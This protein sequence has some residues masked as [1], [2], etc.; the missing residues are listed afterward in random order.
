MSQAGLSWALPAGGPHLWIRFLLA[1]RFLTRYNFTFS[2]FASSHAVIGVIG[3]VQCRRL[4][5]RLVEV[6]LEESF[7]L[8]IGQCHKD[9]SL[10]AMFSVWLSTHL[11]LLFA[12]VAHILALA[13]L[14]S[15]TVLC[16]SLGA[17]LLPTRSFCSTRRAHVLV[18][19]AFSGPSIESLYRMT[20]PSTF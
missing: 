11:C 16:P 20:Q 17:L 13:R 1:G 8:R 14:P 18:V 19:L 7:T 5:S 9:T 6:T 4:H 2:S 3:S 15:L 12:P 10:W